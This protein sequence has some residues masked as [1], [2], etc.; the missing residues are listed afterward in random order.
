MSRTDEKGIRYFAKVCFLTALVL[1]TMIGTTGYAL[2]RAIEGYSPVSYFTENIAERGSSD[3]QHQYK[4][5]VYYFTSN[6][7]LE[8]FK[9]QPEKYVP[10]FGAFCPYSLT[11]GRQQSIDP[12]N[13]KIVGGFLLLFHRTEEKDTFK[14]WNL[15]EDEKDLL[16]KAEE[17]FTLIRF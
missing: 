1:S 3:Y 13:F 6:E 9:V 4:G 8:M 7:Q 5:A 17:Q 2:D 10:H 11:L 12:T 16:K 15:E 14:L